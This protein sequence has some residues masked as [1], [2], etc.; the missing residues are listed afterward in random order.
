[1]AIDSLNARDFL[2]VA[3]VLHDETACNGI[4][5]IEIQDGIAY[6]AGKGGS[7]AAIDVTTPAAPKLLW[8]VRDPQRYEEAETVLPL[9]PDRLLVGTRDALLFDISDP[10]QPRLLSDIVDRTPVNLI[11]GFARHRNTVFGTNKLGHLSAI[12]VARPNAITLAGFQETRKSGGLAQPHDAAFLGDLLI[13]VSAEGFGRNSQPGKLHVYRVFE[14]GTGTLLAAPEWKLIGQLTHPRLAGANRVAVCGPF[15]CV[16]SS[17]SHNFDRS[18]G[19]HSNVALIDLHDPALP[20]LRDSVD[21][22][23]PRGPN[24]LEVAGH[25]AFAAGGRTVLAVDLTDPDA[26][27][28]AARLTSSEAFPGGADDAH[29]LVLHDSHLFVTAQTSHSLVV[30]RVDEA[31]LNKSSEAHGH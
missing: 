12:D 24:G 6:A 16:G 23:D 19:L 10:S 21:F 7:L 9:S 31:L 29:D 17:L 14:P 15:A 20:R 22:P 3:A 26:L 4:H 1:M 11:N 30:L 2:R 25:I 28:I 13:I 8:S 5:D 18:D 27:R